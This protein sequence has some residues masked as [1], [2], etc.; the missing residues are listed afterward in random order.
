MYLVLAL[1]CIRCQ[2]QFDSADFDA[3]PEKQ[4][5]E[6]KQPIAH[7]YQRIVSGELIIRE[8]LFRFIFR[9]LYL[10]TVA[11]VLTIMI[12]V[13]STVRANFSEAIIP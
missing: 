11:L 2:Y 9:S 13:L 6:Y 7:Q 12:A 10:L 4:N 8:K 1:L 3:L 5:D